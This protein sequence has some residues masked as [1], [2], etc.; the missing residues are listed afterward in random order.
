M[1]ASVNGRRSRTNRL[2]LG[3]AAAAVLAVLLSTAATRDELVAAGEGNCSLAALQGALSRGPALEGNISLTAAIAINGSFTPPGAAAP[4]M[5]LPAVCRV[6]A[7]AKP[8]TDSEINFEVWLPAVNW[9]SKYLSVGEGGLHGNINY[10]GLADGVRRGYATASTDAGHRV[11]DRWWMVGH[12][13]KAIDAGYRGKHLQTVGAK[14]VIA[15][16]FDKAPRLSYHAGCSGGGRQALM[17][18]QR[19][20]GDFDGY[21]IGAP[22]NNWTGQATNWINKAQAIADPSSVIPAE[23]LPAIQAA[24]VAQCDAR[25][26]VRDGIVS[27]PR[28]CHFNPDVLACASAKDEGPSCLTPPQLVAL[29]RIFRG[30]VDSK[31]RQIFPGEE[32]GTDILA[33]VGPN[34]VQSY[35]VTT[36]GGLVLNRSDWDARTFDFD[37]DTRLMEEKIGRLFN[38]NDADLRVQ[39]AKGI[40]IIQYHGWAD[41]AL[42]PGESINYYERVIARMGGVADTQSFYRLFMAPGMAHCGGGPGPNRF[43][44]A[45]GQSV[46]ALAPGAT[47]ND[48]VVKALER[49]VEEGVAPDRLVATKYKNDAVTDAPLIRRPL[50]PYP[51]VQKYN[52]SGDPNVAS[53]FSCVAPSVGTR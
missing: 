32:P 4:L 39:K 5:D 20:P 33:S 31:G 1:T 12:P 35:G 3:T 40:K 19:Y 27:E 26:G 37:R 13:E 10:Q 52:G 44:Q 34:L 11:A 7:V 29:K 49:W 50:C 46:A 16:Y 8:S 48:D 2:A 43:G 14:A 25:D 36:M 17:S 41:Q 15:A 23:K 30:P 53:S 47:A 51:Q 22:A 9:N 42:P 24:V 6:S 18:L 21:V 28:Q 45:G 38:A